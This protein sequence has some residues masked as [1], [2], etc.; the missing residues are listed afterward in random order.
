[1]QKFILT[2]QFGNW[3]IGY[4][5]DEANPS[6]SFWHTL[7]DLRTPNQHFELSIFGDGKQI[8]LKNDE[9]F[10]YHQTMKEKLFDGA[11]VIMVTAQIGPQTKITLSKLVVS[12][13]H[14]D[15]IA[16]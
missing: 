5:P 7:E 6:P 12:Q 2:Y 9:G 15:E 4:Q 16:N 13:L 14:K 3:S 11:E 8:S 1:L 10:E